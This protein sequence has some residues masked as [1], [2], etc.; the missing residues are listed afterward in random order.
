MTLSLLWP[1]FA[2]VLLI[3]VVLCVL[4]VSRGRHVAANPPSQDDVANR[5]A[6]SRYFAPVDA[7]AANLANLFEVPVLYFVLVP[8]LMMTRHADH[9]QTALAWI[10]V[11]LRVLHTAVMLGPNKVALRLPVYLASALVVFAMWAI[12]AVEMMSAASA[13]AAAGAA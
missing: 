7:P 1:T 6:A 2:L 11:V 13:L 3:F 8:L 5:F 9:L 12:F 10:F 4:I